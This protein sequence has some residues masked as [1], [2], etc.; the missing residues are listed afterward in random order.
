MR[1]FGE[2]NGNLDSAGF[3]HA[4]QK[5]VGP[6][7]LQIMHVMLIACGLILLITEVRN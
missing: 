7:T 4:F 2:Q 1:S 5:E 6:G 3:A